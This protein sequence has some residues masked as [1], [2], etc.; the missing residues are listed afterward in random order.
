MGLTLLKHLKIIKGYNGIEMKDYDPKGE[1][2][3]MK[4]RETT[5][6]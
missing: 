3:T 5:F 1:V 2:Y 4:A 6:K